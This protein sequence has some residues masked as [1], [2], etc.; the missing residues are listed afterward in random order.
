LREA[1]EN[2]ARLEQE[3]RAA[4]EQ[5]RLETVAE[6]QASLRKKAPQL[7]IKDSKINILY[8]YHS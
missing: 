4:E 7:R 8:S 2:H 5:K 3:L 1:V 6:K